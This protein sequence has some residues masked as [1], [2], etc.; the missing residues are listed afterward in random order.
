MDWITL[1]ILSATSLGFYEISR[2]LSLQKVPALNVLW[3]STIISGLLAVPLAF[4]STAIPF[5]AHLWILL[6]SA[7]ICL[8]WTGEFFALK[9]IPLSIGMAV[10]STGPFFTTLVAVFFFKE[11]PS[12]IEWTGISLVLA[13][14]FNFIFLARFHK[15]TGTLR[16]RWLMLI[17]FATLLG[18]FSSGIDRHILKTLS[19]PPLTFLIWF[20]I[21]IALLISLPMII[22]LINKVALIKRSD[23]VWTIPLIS[24]L[25]LFSDWLYYIALA[26]IDSSLSVVSALRRG[27]LIIS[28]LGGVI[29]FREGKLVNKMIAIGFV[30]AGIVI[31]KLF[32]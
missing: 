25:L 8:S 21:Y 4:Q 14:Y 15:Q 1:S 2:K 6:K 29:I 7:I 22:F 5:K 32:G 10:R 18:T 28:V 9:Q 20:S 3:Y 26:N 12:I 16:Y 27:A 17:F 24:I 30:T 19:V 11:M 23:F 13:G 31:L